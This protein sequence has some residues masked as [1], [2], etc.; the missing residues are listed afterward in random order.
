MTTQETPPAGSAQEL[1]SIMR[2]RPETSA[3]RKPINYCQVFVPVSQNL[4]QNSGI[5]VY[6]CKMCGALIPPAGLSIHDQ[7]HDQLIMILEAVIGP[8]VADLRLLD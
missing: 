2:P 5:L 7:F 1:A 8:A 6:N 4:T 3:A